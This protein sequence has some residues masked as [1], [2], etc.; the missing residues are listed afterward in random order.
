M[1]SCGLALIRE[2][3]APRT[4]P[5]MPLLPVVDSAIALIRTAGLEKIDE[6][7]EMSSYWR[8]AMVAFQRSERRLR[9][10]NFFMPFLSDS[11]LDESHEWSN[12][13]FA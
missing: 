6:P 3:D 1:P 13:S 2:T 11:I 8:R 4:R 9:F 7:S 5:I 10:R 12:G